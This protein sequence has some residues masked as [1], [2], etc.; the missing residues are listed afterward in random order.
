MGLFNNY[1]TP[2]GWVVLIGSVHTNAISY[3]NAYNASKCMRFHKKTHYCGRY[4]R[5]RPIS[6]VFLHVFC[7]SERDAGGSKRQFQ[8]DASIEWFIPPKG[9]R[10]LNIRL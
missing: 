6:M 1:V 7:D 9:D 5:D 10:Y 8:S 4:Y 2:R 3:K